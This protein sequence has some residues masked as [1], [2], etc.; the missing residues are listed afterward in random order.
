MWFIF[1]SI[2]CAGLGALIGEL[3]KHA[4]GIGALIGFG[5]NCLGWM[6]AMGGA[7]AAGDIIGSI[8]D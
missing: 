4:P 3:A 6:I 1:T 8:F 5:V 7:E 2:V